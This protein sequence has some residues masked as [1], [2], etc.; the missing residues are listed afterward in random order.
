[1]KTFDKLLDLKVD[2][3]LLNSSPGNPDMNIQ[4]YAGVDCLDVSSRF[5][6]DLKK[7]P[8]VFISDYKHK[9]KVKKEKGRWNEMMQVI[10]PKKRIGVNAN[11]LTLAQ[12]KALKKKRVKLVDIG[13]ELSKIRSVKTKK[14]IENITSACKH[15]RKALAI[16]KTKI[17]KGSRETEVL[18]SLVDYYA[19]NGLRLAFDPIVQGAQNTKYTHSYPTTQKARGTVIVD[20][21]CRVN[22]Y[23]SDL[24]RTFG[25]KLS[26]KQGE[27]IELVK[28]AN[29]FA[30][31]N[32]EI[33]MPC[34]DLYKMTKKFLGN[35]AKYWRYGLG[36]GVGLDIHEAPGI[37]LGS[38]DV[39]E[40]NMVFTIEPG[41]AIPGIGGARYEL[42][43]V[44][45]RK[46][47]KVL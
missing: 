44:L 2:A 45:T 8:V 19:K 17:E 12:V 18:A 40:K 9:A 22:G 14:E 26:K 20:T 25:Y 39:F 47:F 13:K 10:K 27:V 24:T 3:V 29:K 21:G 32:V 4:Y 31:Q 46:G 15:T 6:Y 35:K 28:K 23:C 1:M 5:Y 34:E 42:T 36:H 38:E 30:V 37:G 16:A 7:S 11:H 41:L 33:G 43:G